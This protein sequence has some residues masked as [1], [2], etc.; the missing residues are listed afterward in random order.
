MDRN[1]QKRTQTDRGHEGGDGHQGGDSPTPGYTDIATYRLNWP[2]GRFS[3]NYRLTMRYRVGC[4]F[5][6]NI[7]VKLAKSI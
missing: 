3:E 1:R 2:R 5:T 7:L 4:E 6:D